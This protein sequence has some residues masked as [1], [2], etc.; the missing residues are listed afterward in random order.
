MRDRMLTNE[1]SSNQ[2]L[3]HHSSRI[4]SR[5]HFMLIGMTQSPIRFRICNRT[6]V[7]LTTLL[8]MIMAMWFL[9]S[10]LAT[11]STFAQVLDLD[12]VHIPSL[13]EL[14]IAQRTSVE[15]EA[16]AI[17]L[18]A[19]AVD[20]SGMNRLILR[21][22]ARW[23]R[24]A[25]ELLRLDSATDRT[26][27][28]HSKVV[29]IAHLYGHTLADAAAGID[30]VLDRAAATPAGGA[31][32]LSVQAVLEQYTLS[33][34]ESTAPLTVHS[35]H[36]V[37]SL[38]YWLQNRFAPLLEAVA[39]LDDSQSPMRCW[40]MLS[41]PSSA[42]SSNSTPT[43]LALNELSQE[44]QLLDSNAPLSSDM[45][46]VMVELQNAQQR[47][48]MSSRQ[49]QDDVLW[50]RQ[51]IELHHAMLVATGQADDATSWLNDQT[52]DCL[53]GFIQTQLKQW[54]S[55][56]ISFDDWQLRRRTEQQVAIWSHLIN[57]A[58][59]LAVR[60]DQQVNSILR[61]LSRFLAE[62]F[63]DADAIVHINEVEQAR[64]LQALTFIRRMKSFRQMTARRPTSSA[65]RT[66][67]QTIRQRYTMLEKKAIQV[68]ASSSDW[69]VLRSD[70]AWVML[71]ASLYA[72]Y[73]DVLLT[74]NTGEWEDALLRHYPK[75]ERAY[76]L[77]LR[78]QI[79]DLKDPFSRPAAAATLNALDQQVRRYNLLESDL[80]AIAL[81]LESI[82]LDE[83]RY[84][85]GRR[86]LRDQTNIHLRQWASQWSNGNVQSAAND[87]MDALADWLDL[88][89]LFG[90]SVRYRENASAHARWAAWN[91][92]PKPGA[93]DQ[94]LR[95]LKRVIAQAA[96]NESDP[97]KL[98]QISA[99]VLQRVNRMDDLAI[100]VDFSADHYFQQASVLPTG[101]VGVL[102]EIVIPP[103][104][105]ANQTSLHAFRG[106]LAEVG[107][108]IRERSHLHPDVPTTIDRQLE[109][110]FDQVADE[111]ATDLENWHRFRSDLERSGTGKP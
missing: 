89:A 73:D 60:R 90:R 10:T 108:L 76:R 16:Q 42:Q 3:R 18:D 100:I 93:L 9:T 74:L 98:L 95:D 106:R 85:M 11:M 62:R 79:L 48:A 36:E 4:S 52:A 70:P 31:L 83:D 56:P 22:Q 39:L 21:A 38:D 13:G 24:D 30:S 82:G 45:Q 20:E 94:T 69:T 102:S 32:R 51:L 15:L 105:Q 17:Q 104:R 49:F 44:S 80:D 99:E 63:P 78:E 33:E 72:S 54:D 107:C 46:T 84:R 101:V 111:L 23:R 47:T 6:I 40:P 110:Y 71:R 66:L 37:E 25:C 19:Q 96:A 29:S 12:R 26:F 59:E 64:L 65:V 57:Q 28:T 97:S 5:M 27:T 34:D 77:F 91:W 87:R 67:H 75:G 55:D 14:S 53:T 68:L 50:I 88:I 86:R 8:I 81:T 92:Q 61:T 41:T 35:E 7:S 58:N 2:L 109:A 1:R 103:R 43:Q